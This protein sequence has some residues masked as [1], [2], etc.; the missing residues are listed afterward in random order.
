MATAIDLADV[1]TG[2]TSVARRY[3]TVATGGGRRSNASGCHLS[4]RERFDGASGH[5][6]RDEPLKHTNAL[7]ELGLGPHRPCEVSLQ[8][9][10]ALGC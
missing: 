1:T 5:V 2:T 3:G 6:L 7:P 10:L 8:R 9:G 4:V